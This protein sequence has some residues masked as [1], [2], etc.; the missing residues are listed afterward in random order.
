LSNKWPEVSL[1]EV[2]DR[3]TDGTHHSPTNLPTG[4][5]RY[6]TAKNIRPWGLDLS[7][8]SYVD[9]KTHREIYS[10]CPVEQGDVLYIKDGATTGLA[11]VNPLKEPF[12]MLSSVA[13][14]KPNREAL[15]PTYLKHWLNSPLTVAQMTSEMTGTAIKRLVLRQIR[16]ARIPLPTIGQQRIVADKL[17]VLLAKVDLCR[18]R[19]DRV[20]QILKRFREAV[21]EAAVS[22]RLTEEW[23]KEHGNSHDWQNTTLGDVCFV[24]KLAGFEYTKFVKY[25]ED[26]DLKVIKAEN[27][28]HWGFKPTSYSRVR[29]AEVAGLTRSRLG[30]GD[31]LMVFVGAGTG[32][33]A[34]VPPG[35]DWFLGPNIAMIRPNPSKLLPTYL[36]HYF[37]SRAGWDQIAL[38]MK[39]VAQPS[40]SMKTIRLMEISLPSSEEQTAI[41]RRVDDLFA[42]ADRLQRRYENAVP[43][44]DRM[45]PSVLAKAFRGELVPQDPSDEPATEMLERLSRIN[46]GARR[47]SRTGRARE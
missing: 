31:V 30:E 8:I 13:L 26:G 38:Y 9:E 27:A 42:L 6:V 10:R 46:N 3:I 11:V 32:R 23:R 41:V 2:C 47:P 28:G 25:Q 20:P 35:D 7:D 5:Y 24:T 45:T 16:A 43:R 21:L 12:S 15:E 40:L 17:D 33:V 22:G 18:G 4:A 29:S 14:L 36:D 37:R 19:L 1:A 44:V 39:S 34:R